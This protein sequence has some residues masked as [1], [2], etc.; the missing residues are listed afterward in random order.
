ML[1][2]FS[3]F[4]R[5]EKPSTIPF[6]GYYAYWF[7]T[8]S[9]YRFTNLL[10]SILDKENKY[11]EHVENRVKS[12]VILDPSKSLIFKI[13]HIERGLR[14][15]VP[16]LVDRIRRAQLGLVRSVA[17]DWMNYRGKISEAMKLE[18]E[19][20]ASVFM[21]AN[22]LRRSVISG[23]QFLI[24]FKDPVFLRVFGRCKTPI[25]EQW[26]LTPFSLNL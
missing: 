2:P 12:V 6:K 17:A 11:D 15:M 18:M 23:T 19:E 16:A 20:L 7:T 8:P 26:F 24:A 9:I 1:R 22:R 14:L 13:K 5:S 4:S 10:R 21:D 25:S 3:L